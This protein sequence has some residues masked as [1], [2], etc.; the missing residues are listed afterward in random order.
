LW[1]TVFEI[2]W[3]FSIKYFVPFALN[4]L[5][6][7]SLKGDIETPYGGYHIFW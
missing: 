2:W 1:E 5:I 6:F 7:F 3:G 4:F